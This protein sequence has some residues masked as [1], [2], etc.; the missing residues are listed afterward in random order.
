MAPRSSSPSR[1]PLSRDAVLRAAIT[2]ADAQGLDALS[3]RALGAALGVQA[4]SLYHHVADKDAVLDAII[5]VVAGEIELP[6]PEGPWKEAMRKR[7][8]SAHTVLL[9]HPWACGLLMS[10]IHVGPLMLRYVDS[11]LGCLQ[12]GGFSLP[13]ADRVWNTLDS[14][15]YGFT[16]QKLRFPIRPDN[17]AATAAGFLHLLPQDQYPAMFVLTAMVAQGEHLGLHD[18][19]FGLDLLLDGLERMREGAR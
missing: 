13:M 14:Y 1:A 3:M 6:S 8:L 10:R 12:A 4:M 17:Y 11:T 16:L 5:D 9:R 18:L 19:E 15:T 2:I 7:A